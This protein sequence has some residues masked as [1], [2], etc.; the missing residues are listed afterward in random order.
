M[1]LYVMLLQVL[2]LPVV[3]DDLTLCITYI[4][5]LMLPVL[6]YTLHI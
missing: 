4:A 5:F 3:S 1:L 6:R 2:L